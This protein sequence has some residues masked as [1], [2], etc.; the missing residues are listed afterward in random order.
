MHDYHRLRAWKKAREI[1]VDVY[2]LVET[3]PSR[4]QFGLASQMRRC[5]VSIASNIAEGAARG[6]TADFRRYLRVAAGS[7][8]ELE[9]QLLIAIDVGAL[10][11]EA[12]GPVLDAVDHV[13]RMLMNLERT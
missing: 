3:M 8:S 10:G 9:T 6:T 13:R 7:A 1:A 11:S 2:Q 4:E 5:A 12:A